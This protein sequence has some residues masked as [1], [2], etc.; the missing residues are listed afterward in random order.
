MF[1]GD[2]DLA[3]AIRI[4]GLPR[5]QAVAAIGFGG[6][7]ARNRTNRL[8]FCAV[9]ASRNCSEACRILRLT[10]TAHSK[11][12]MFL[13]VTQKLYAPVFHASSVVKPCASRISLASDGVPR[14]NPAAQIPIP[15][16]HEPHCASVENSA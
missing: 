16:R 11:P 1:V 6:M 7:A 4:R 14:S 5:V 12:L 3:F 13:P 9:A 10:G 15:N 2:F 8:R